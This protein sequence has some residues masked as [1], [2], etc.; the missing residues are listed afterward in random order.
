M[1]EYVALDSLWKCETCFNYY[2]D[3]C[4]DSMWCENGESYRPAYD[5]LTIVECEPIKYALWLFD[6]DWYGNSGVVCSECH[7]CSTKNDMEVM[8]YKRCPNCGAHM[9]NCIR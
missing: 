9:R 3:K 1:S 6:S 8:K 7:W 2:M 5:K 4:S